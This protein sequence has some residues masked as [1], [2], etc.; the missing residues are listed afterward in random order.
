ME[1]KRKKRKKIKAVILAIGAFVLGFFEGFLED[2]LMEF[3][4]PLGMLLH[5][6]L[7]LPEY[8][9]P[10]MRHFFL[11]TLGVVA[12]VVVFWIIWRWCRKKNWFSEKISPCKDDWMTPREKR[13]KRLKGD[14][15]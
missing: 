8:T 7:G 2:F 12:V 15:T 5:Q 11:Y 14:E 3:E 1:Q 6:A 4:E 10:F 9:K 13:P